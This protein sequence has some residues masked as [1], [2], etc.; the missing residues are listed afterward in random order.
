M[1]EVLKVRKKCHGRWIR[2]Y[3]IFMRVFSA[4]VAIQEQYRC[5]LNSCNVKI[6]AVITGLTSV[7]LKHTEKCSVLCASVKVLNVM[8]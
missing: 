2:L 4:F 3:F 8:L 1:R 5:R 7:S 6:C